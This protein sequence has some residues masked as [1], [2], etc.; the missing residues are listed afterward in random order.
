MNH[1]T[2][3]ELISTAPKIVKRKLE[4]LQFLR[5]RPDYHPEKSV[6]DHIKIVTTRLMETGNPNLILAGV[7]HDIRKFDCVEMNPKSGY[8]TSPGHDASAAHFIYENEPIQNWIELNGGDPDIVAHI[9]KEHMRIKQID[10]MKPSKQQSIKELPI[11]G[12]LLEFTKAD[13]MLEEYQ[14]IKN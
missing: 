14:Y 9:C 6:A 1:K 7:F 10:K 8:P 3:E 11:Y 13:I 4:Q 5:E 12:M 2:F